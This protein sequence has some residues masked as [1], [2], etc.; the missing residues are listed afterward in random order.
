[1][2]LVIGLQGS[3]RPKMNTGALL[4]AA[5]AGA[6]AAG[7]ETRMFDIPRLHIKPCVACYQCAQTGACP[8]NDDMQAIFQ[9][10]EEA[11]GIL[12]ATPLF[13]NALS[14]QLKSAVDRGQVYWSR[15]YRLHLPP[16]KEQKP[17]RGGFL[18]TGGAPNRSGKNFEP[19]IASLKLLFDDMNL[20]WC[21]EVL[22]PNTDTL[23]V[24][25]NHQALQQARDLGKKLAGA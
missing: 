20:E 21:G 3:P 15:K 19:S 22:I 13:F 17:R 12:F 6:K 8:V 5:L 25:E 2:T 7:A 11:D 4:A 1:M 14:A 18:A 10:Y 23:P 24:W 16:F 9:A